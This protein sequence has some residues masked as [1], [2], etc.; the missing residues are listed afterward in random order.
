MCHV[1]SCAAVAA[2]GFKNNRYSLEGWAINNQSVALLSPLANASQYLEGKSYPTSNLVIPSMYGCIELLH[3]D[4]PVRQPW[5]SKLLQPNDMRPEVMD[6]R[7]DLYND[8]V[9]RWKTELPSE[10]K[11]FYF[12]ATICD[13]RQKGLAFPGVTEAERLAAHEWFQAEFTSLWGGPAPEAAPAAAAPAPAPTPAP[14]P[15][16]SLGSFMD[17]MASVSHLQTPE[18]PQALVPVVKSEAERYLE[19]PA[20]P[21]K[22]DPLEWWAENEIDFPALSIMARQYL[23]IPATSASAERLFSIAGRAFDDLR[24]HMKEQ[25]LEMLMWARINREKRQKA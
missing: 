14:T 23:G 1:L 25:M 6:G 12:I 11:R 21:M 4:A 10:L 7:L 24:Q 3:A 9:R 16:P 20:A 22:T 5:D 19:L 2:D 15:P 13:P 8:L 18:L 17:F